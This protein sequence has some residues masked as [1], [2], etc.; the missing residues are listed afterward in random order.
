MTGR[1]R[2]R[3]TPA[4]AE[5]RK[6]ARLATVDPLDPTRPLP[7]LPFD[8]LIEQAFDLYKAICEAEG[9]DW[10]AE[11]TEGRMTGRTVHEVAIERLRQD[12]DGGRQRRIGDVPWVWPLALAGPDP[13]TDHITSILWAADIPASIWQKIAASSERRAV[14]A[15]RAKH[16]PASVRE[17][18]ARHEQT[19]VRSAVAVNECTPREILMMLT[20][21]PWP[22]VRERVAMNRKC[23]LDALEVLAADPDPRVRRTVASE[24]RTPRE[25]LEVL[26]ADTVVE[27]RDGARW[28]L[29]GR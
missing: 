5:R 11:L 2:R 23:P 4:Q 1:R 20:A 13:S 14:D 29:S 17:T 26:A 28:T 9:V 7:D 24:P 22:G 15:A 8:Q 27:V 3:R 19:S 10:Q 25:V 16:T 12:P 18:L 6:A 21:D